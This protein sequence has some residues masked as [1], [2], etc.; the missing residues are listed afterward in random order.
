MEDRG[1]VAI[2]DPRVHTKNYGRMFMDSLPKCRETGEIEEVRK[3]FEELK[4]RE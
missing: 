1:M 3:F 2:L 4:K